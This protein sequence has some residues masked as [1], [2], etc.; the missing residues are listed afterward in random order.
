V[1]YRDDVDKPIQGHILAKPRLKLIP[2]VPF[3]PERVE[4]VGIRIGKEGRVE[5]FHEEDLPSYLKKLNS[6][7]AGEKEKCRR[8]DNPFRIAVEESR[9]VDGVLLL[10]RRRGFPTL[11]KGP[12]LLKDEPLFPHLQERPFR[13]DRIAPHEKTPREDQE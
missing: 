13:E 2:G 11:R 1:G 5:N 7:G 9:R 4:A 12:S 6:L 10:H 3:M 8:R